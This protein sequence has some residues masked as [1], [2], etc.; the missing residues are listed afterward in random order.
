ME[1]VWQEQ[2]WE[3]V[4]LALLSWVG[5]ILFFHGEFL[6]PSSCLPMVQIMNKRLSLE[7][8]SVELI[9]V[10]NSGLTLIKWK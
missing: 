3:S 8:G 9:K 1:R 5:T 4:F 6:V 2:M 10:N 7:Q